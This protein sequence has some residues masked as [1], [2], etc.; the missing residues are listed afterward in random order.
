[1]SGSNR[2]AWLKPW[3]R[4]L[5]QLEELRGKLRPKS[6][7]K[8]SASKRTGSDQHTLSRRANLVG[9]FGNSLLELFGGWL[10]A[11]QSQEMLQA[12][13]STI[14]TGFASYRT[15]AIYGDLCGS[16]VSP[17]PGEAGRGGRGR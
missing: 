2:G 4:N 5:W 14:I 11:E 17:D 9:P 3:R 16:R 1:M 6:A 12:I 7:K 13:R 8:A 15:V 10:S